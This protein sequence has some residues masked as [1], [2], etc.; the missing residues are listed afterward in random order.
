MRCAFASIDMLIEMQHID[1]AVTYGNEAEVGDGLRPALES[2]AVQREDLFVTTKLWSDQHAKDAVVP[3]L[4]ESLKKLRLDFVDLF[5]VHWPITDHHGP[6]LEPP[7]QV[8][9]FVLQIPSHSSGTATLSLA[10]AQRAQP[11]C[12]RT[13]QISY[14]CL[15]KCDII[16]NTTLSDGIAFITKFDAC[17]CDTFITKSRFISRF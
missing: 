13:Y 6:T 4:R 5:L 7:M 15:G 14:F 17:S 2:G 1:T 9:V 3:V 10:V 11:S 12:S 16:C 8:G